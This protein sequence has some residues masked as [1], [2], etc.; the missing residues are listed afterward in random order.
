MALVTNEF[1]PA[2]QLFEISRQARLELARRAAKDG[3]ILDWGK[4]LFPHKFN[5]PYCAEL[6]GYFVAIRSEP[7]TN[8]EAPR[9][10]SKTT[11]KCFLI[12]LFQALNE[13]ERFRHY[14]N[15]QATNAKALAVNTAIKGEIETNEDLRALYGNMIGPRWTDQQF[16]LRN[17]VVF[18]AVG[19]GQSIRGLNY[20]SDR[21][22]YFV[23]DDLYDE[24][25]INNIESTIKKK[26]WFW[27]SLYPARAQSRPCSMH[28]Q[29]TAIND[30]DVLQDLKQ[31]KRW[32]S[33]TFKAVKDWD[34]KIA[35]WPELKSFDSLMQDMTDM[36]SVIFMREMQNERRDD[37]TSIVKRGWLYPEGRAS[38]E[39]DPRELEHRFEI[40]R[41]RFFV[42]SVIVGNDPSIGKDSEADA[43][44]TVLVLETQYQDGSGKE[45]WIESIWN[46]RI[47]LDVRVRQL[48]EIAKMRPAGR[49]ITRVRI[50][51]I[52]GFND[53]AD[54][55][56]R[57][58]NLPV[59]RVDWVKDKISTLESKSHYFENR[60]VH[61][62]GN[63]DPAIK[64]TLVHQLT[65]N[66][67]KHDDLRDALLLTLDDTQGLW[68]FVV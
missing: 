28:V 50:E 1:V 32:K 23:V 54:E 62:N 39:Y 34:R 5:L 65:T 35:L 19:A 4:A 66:H 15:V 6:H 61:L 51:A 8:T 20:K 63:I 31:K 57:R 68:N 45:Y 37:A 55:V 25:D 10:H 33:A 43:T 56:I 27:S 46:E 36:G 67:P 52:A 58:T 12:P 44:G 47:S 18:T 22:D 48:Q 49:A 9:N 29:G 2:A 64:D 17:G 13:P 60:K 14:L 30:E 59:Q 24:E 40:E 53:Y 21:P 3:R 42:S 7:F 41:P 16:V 26:V 38:W 11:I